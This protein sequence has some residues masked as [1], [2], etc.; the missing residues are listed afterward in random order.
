VKK[1]GRKTFITLIRGTNALFRNLENLAPLPKGLSLSQFGVLEALFHKGALC[2]HQL[3]EKVLKTRGNMSLVIKNLLSKG[4]IIKVEN[5]TD[6]RSYSVELTEKGDSLIRSVLPHH[7]AS[8][9]RMME[10]LSAQELEQLSLL[11]KKL[12]KTQK[13]EPGSPGF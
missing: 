5:S 9:D 2:P 4:L 8:I 13:T 10:V 6:K 11:L 3:S 7:L 1:Q 12:G